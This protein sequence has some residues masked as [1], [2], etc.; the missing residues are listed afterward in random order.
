MRP[1]THAGVRPANLRDAA[2]FDEVQRQVSDL[3]KGR[4]VVGHAIDNDL[5]VGWASGTV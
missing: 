3:L 2:P 1:R 5:E 4:I